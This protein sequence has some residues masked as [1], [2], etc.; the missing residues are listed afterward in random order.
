[1]EA[2]L[3]EAVPVVPAFEPALRN[4]LLELIN[5]SLAVW[6]YCLGRLAQDAESKDAFMKEAFPNAFGN[7]QNS[8]HAHQ[9]KAMNQ[10]KALS[11]SVV[12]C[13]VRYLLAEILELAGQCAR[14]SYRKVI[15]PG[16]IRRAIAND[17]EMCDECLN[18]SKVFWPPDM[19]DAT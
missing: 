17:Q 19:T 1:M 11:M 16:D 8:I 6:I 3:K 15:V 18:G 4:E 2:I 10:K 13:G 7:N 12:S 5:E 9:I 14:D